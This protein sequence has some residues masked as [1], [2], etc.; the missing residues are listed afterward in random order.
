MRRIA[1]A[2]INTSCCIGLSMGQCYPEPD[3]SLTM[4]LSY[5]LI[6]PSPVG[7]E[8]LISARL[9]SAFGINHTDNDTHQL[10]S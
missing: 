6:A 10:P 7:I 2:L 4:F 5:T 8:G 9:V 3:L 1:L